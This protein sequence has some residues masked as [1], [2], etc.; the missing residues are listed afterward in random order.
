MIVGGSSGMGRALAAELVAQGSE[1]TVAGRAPAKL[2][3][4]RRELG[5][6]TVAMDLGS[7]QDIERL[8]ATTGKVSHIVTTAADVGGAY[9]PIAKYD[10]AAARSAVD[11]K[12]IGPLLLAK[13]GAPML[14]PGGGS[15]VFTSGIAA[16]RPGPRASLLAALNGALASLAAALAVE[17]APLRVNVVSP[18]WVD[19]PIW[20]DVAGDAAPETLSAM[21]ARLPVGRIGRPQDIA[22]AIIALLRNGFI[23]GTVLHADG[24]HRLA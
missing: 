1:V 23:T 19:T 17:L 3:A 13:H 7:E 22:A 6:R 11:S 16:Y 8:F 12:L 9:Q 18:G 10:V 5:V 2:D 14:E 15:I 24:G 4:V 21:A 20:K